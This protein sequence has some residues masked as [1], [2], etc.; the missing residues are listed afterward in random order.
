MN[1]NFFTS[2]YTFLVLSQL[3][4]YENATEKGDIFYYSAFFTKDKPNIVAEELVYMVNNI[5]F[6]NLMIFQISEQFEYKCEEIKQFKGHGN[7]ILTFY[8]VN[9]K[10]FFSIDFMR[11]LVGYLKT[12]KGSNVVI[13]YEGFSLKMIKTAFKFIGIQISG[14]NNTLKLFHRSNFYYLK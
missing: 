14:G 8:K 7:S 2:I 13:F 3:R 1:N 4:P 9:P 6:K 12:H 10:V 5:Y 11:N